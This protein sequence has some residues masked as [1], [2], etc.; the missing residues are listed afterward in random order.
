MPGNVLCRPA[1]KGR[2][3]GE[4]RVARRWG[5]LGSSGGVMWRERALRV[6]VDSGVAWKLERS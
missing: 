4:P 1:T 3:K 6:V 2:F 5:R